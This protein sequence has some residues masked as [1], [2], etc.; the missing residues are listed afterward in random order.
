MQLKKLAIHGFKSFADKT[1]LHFDE[2]ITCIV[3]PNGCGKSNIS[4]AFRW[5]LGEQS[6]KSMRG[7][8]MPDIIFAGSTH[9]KC[10]NFA[11]V[12]LT[13]TDVNRSLPVDYEEVTITRRL[14]RDGESEYLLNGNTIRLKDLQSL[15]L[16]SGIGK[17]AFSI[18]EQGKLDQVIS[19]TPLERRHI[20]EEAAG[21]LRFL[22]RKKEALKRLEQADLN[23]SRV[24]DIHSEVHKQIENLEKQAEKAR[25]YK[26]QKQALEVLEKSNYVLK[27]QMI[28]KKLLE[29]QSKQEKEQ[30][31]LEE[32]QQKL[33]T[34]NAQYQQ[35]KE[36]KL[37]H[38]QGMHELK[39]KLVYLRGRKENGDRELQHLQQRAKEAQQR[40]KKLQIEF[41]ELSLSCQTR[42]ASLSTL[43]VA[44]NRLDSDW[45]E[46]EINWIQMQEK[47]KVQ[48]KNVIRLRQALAEKQQSYLTCLQQNNRLQTELKQVEIRVENF[49]DQQKQTEA[50]HK[51]LQ[52]EFQQIS[53]LTKERK[54]SLQ[55]FSDVVDS[56]KDR[57]DRYE[58][59]IKQINAELDKK[60]QEA[61]VLRRRIMEIK[62][63][64]KVLMRMR[65]E[66]EGFSSGSKKL[67]Q[68]SQDS[69]SPIFQLLRPLYEFFTPERETAQALAIVLRNYTQTLVI[70]RESDFDRVIAFATQENLQDYSLVCI[71]LV[72]RAYP[73]LKGFDHQLLF[74]DSISNILSKHFLASFTKLPAQEEGVS[75][76]QS[77]K[78][79]E[80]WTSDGAYIDHRCV[81]FKLTAGD[82]QIFLRESELLQ[83][84][85]E[86]Q[87][88]QDVLEKIDQSLLQYQHRRSHTQLE[89]NE[90]DKILRRDE[91]KLVEINFGL[92]RV[93]SDAEKNK[94][95]QENCEK[96]LILA[97]QNCERQRQAHLTLEQQWTKEQQEWVELQKETE[98]FQSQLN[99]QETDLRLEMDKQ[100]EDEI[101]FH[102]IRE[103]RQKVLHQYNLLEM[104]EQE[105]E[106]NA[107]RI[108]DE[109]VELEERK[110]DV[111][112]E[113]KRQNANLALIETEIR[114]LGKQYEDKLATNKILEGQLEAIHAECNQQET[115]SKR[116][117]IDLSQLQVQVVQQKSASET[118]VHELEERFHLTME[119]ALQLSLPVPISLEQ[120]ERQIKAM[121]LTLQ[122]TGDV[123]LAA[124]E[125]LEKHQVRYTFLQQQV[126]DMQ[127]S[128]TELLKIIQD[129]DAES[130]KLFKET[131]EAI[132]NNF[133]KNFQ[134]LFSG[135]EADLQFTDSED[136][137]EAGIDISAKPPG[138]QMRSISLL[139]G[140]EKCLTAVALLFAIFEVKPA[141]FC[142]LD[143]IDAPL[144]DANVERFIN[145]VKHFVDRCQF[146]IITHNKRTMAIG[147]IL[148]GVSMEER[149]V[150]KLL[151]LE[152][153]KRE[154]KVL[155]ET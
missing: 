18:F 25:A 155:V 11:E 36:T 141:P 147:D 69:K 113:E 143:E 51:Q 33:S 127:E 121:R 122:E 66:L 35:N 118:L 62:A 112:G 1:I 142:I 75:L 65:E 32:S 97:V 116:A 24:L 34:A 95:E 39:E 72:L 30:K 85:E 111:Q 3:G 61:E 63:R 131:F 79:Q 76:R 138:K 78:L 151:T 125:E 119:G 130:Y 107:R 68:E 49:S 43:T 89:R 15:F 98:I 52:A 96:E 133:K 108:E 44:R 100:K 14:H 136:I 102:Q 27:W 132:R 23:L 55:Q 31:R 13:L 128:K 64:Q 56:H 94:L 110:V 29:F 50:R 71:E 5:V 19:N 137:L 77:E 146:L 16:G 124:I 109:L 115:I 88:E 20:F 144:D 74:G 53:L 129:L 42:Q 149:G 28:G 59:E 12:S 139:S 152:F 40:I 145:V 86:C 73:F 47:T 81:F 58:E 22:Q 101:Y 67:L 114:E 134:I 70:E 60:Q 84:E 8:K 104:K 93:A 117:E 135:G 80:T 154:S 54:K 57:L 150:S 153:A 106:K 4:D 48:E 120:N 82:N 7:I 126:G 140:G 91:M 99:R 45:K 90:L 148:F 6:A 83:L 92:Q 46:A 26:E 103:D 105:H 17:D 38:E 2:G 37:L 9:R 41:E 123:N 87:A 10:A 21:I